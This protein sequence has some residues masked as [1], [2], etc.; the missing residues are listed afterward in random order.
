MDSVIVHP[1][2]L[3][4]H[5]EFAEHDVKSA[6]NNCIR[7]RRREDCETYEYIAVGSDQNGRLI[8]MV[9]ERN[10]DDWLIY[11]ALTP[12]SKKTLKE[13]GLTGGRDEQERDK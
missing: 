2:V 12:P 1:R 13:L 10:N 4:R 11:H 5:P 6:W 3:E 7:Y 9:A 8:E